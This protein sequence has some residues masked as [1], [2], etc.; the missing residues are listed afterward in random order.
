MGSIHP[1]HLCYHGAFARKVSLKRLCIDQ[2]GAAKQRF[3]DMLVT[4]EQTSHDQR[5]PNIRF[6]QRSHNIAT[7]LYLDTWYID[8]THDPT[9]HVPTFSNPPQPSPNILHPHKRPEPPLH[10]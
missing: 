8:K 1:F 9:T 5:K 3:L 2:I 10:Q 7:V 4:Q 6:E